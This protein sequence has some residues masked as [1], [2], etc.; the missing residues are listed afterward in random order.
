MSNEVGDEVSDVDTI[1]RQ[2]ALEFR[3][4]GRDAPSGVV[5]LGARWIRWA[6]RATLIVLAVAVTGT[7]VV[8]TDESATGP[9]VVDGRTGAVA[10]LLPIV[11][12]PDLAGSTVITITLPGRPPDRI[13]GLHAQLA[14][15]TSAALAGLAPLSQPAILMTGRLA[16]GTPASRT[17][18]LRTTASVV[19]RSESLADVLARQFNA[20]L[21]RGTTP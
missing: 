12:G 16:P 17:A 15:E 18:R 19:L 2:E 9:A 10:A 20:M 1:F 14:S 13:T 7:F 6:Y 21:G 8:R 4:R 11:I 5:R 3:A